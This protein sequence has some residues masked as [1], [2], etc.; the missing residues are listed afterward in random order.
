MRSIDDA[1]AGGVR[2]EERADLERPFAGELGARD[3][4]RRQRVLGRDC[5]GRRN[6]P[7][8]RRARF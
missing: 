4:P 3:C 7:F 8:E 5:F 6:F 2:F 1:A